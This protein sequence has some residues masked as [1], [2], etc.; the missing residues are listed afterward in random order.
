MTRF[1]A[2]KAWLGGLGLG[3]GLVGIALAWRWLVWTAVALLGVA[4]L[5]RFGE[6]APRP[7]S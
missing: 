7:G 6:R 5:L 2:H 3:G 4:F 1:F